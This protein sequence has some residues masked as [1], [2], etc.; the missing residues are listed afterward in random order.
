MADNKKKRGLGRGLSALIGGVEE[1]TNTKTT[2]KAGAQTSKAK[3]KAAGAKKP[4]EPSAKQAPA[5]PLE[6]AETE[7][8]LSLIDPDRSQPRQYFDEE[9]LEELTASI[10][11]HGVIQPLLVQKKGNRY[12]IVAGE[13]RWRAAKE[14]G[15]KKV[16]VVVK[17]FTK[18]SGLEVS[19]IE[20]LQREDLNPLEEAKAYKRLADEFSMKQDEIASKVGK[21]RAAVTNTM[22][23][24]NLDDEVQSYIAAG[25]L[26]EG[27]AKVLLGIG[28]KAR[29]RQLAKQTL[30]GGW[31]VRMLEKAA[32]EAKDAK[33]GVK[34]APALSRAE[35]LIYDQAGR[36]MQEILGTKVAIHHK[37]GKGKIEIAYYSVEELERLMNLLRS[38][39]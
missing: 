15:L 17:S 37:E 16:P 13:R 22:R 36:E 14:A 19:L 6:P 34:K 9:A 12:V 2:A 27:H 30:Q 35:Q 29:Q 31:S 23:L 10:R 1:N 7:I 3:G 11:I 38:L 39:G 24:L 18:E 32:K 4:S 26:S 20:N 8:A 28:D 21:S 25:E 5:A 33:K